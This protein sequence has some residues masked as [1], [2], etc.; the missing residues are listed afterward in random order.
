MNVTFD[1]LA[2][3]SPPRRAARRADRGWLMPV[4]AIA[5]VGLAAWQLIAMPSAA[6]APA[7][8]V[9][10]L[11]PSEAVADPSVPAATTVTFPEVGSPEPISTF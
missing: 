8:P 3:P 2:R 1:Q 9:T 6:V 4:A 7:V 11:M 5:V 10:A